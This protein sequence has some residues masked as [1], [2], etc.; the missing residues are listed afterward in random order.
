MVGVTGGTGGLPKV[1]GHFVSGTSILIFCQS[2]RDESQIGAAWIFLLERVGCIFVS[3]SSRARLL[4][5]VMGGPGGLL[6]V[7]GH[8]VSGTSYLIQSRSMDQEQR[9]TSCT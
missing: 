8:F 2:L 3:A 1:H 9:W 7:H 6:K 5:G 4:L